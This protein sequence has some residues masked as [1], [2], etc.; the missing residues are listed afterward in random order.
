VSYSI[1]AN[2][3][4]F[5]SDRGSRFHD[6]ARTFLD[7]CAAGAEVLCLA[8][9]TVMAYLRIST[10]PR[11]FGAPLSPSDAMSNMEAL[12]TLPHVRSIAEG[13][14]FWARYRETVGPTRVRGNLVPD[15][16]LVALLR[17]HDVRTLY[18]HDRDFLKFDH[19][20]V[21]DPFAKD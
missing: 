8:W 15:A 21:R 17:H 9:P 12:L 1:D 19:L 16:H 6:R 5:A 3:L 20:D 4:L 14:D 7:E 18:T 2:V 11:I 10:H 13:E